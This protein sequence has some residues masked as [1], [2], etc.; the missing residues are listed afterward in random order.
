MCSFCCS[1]GP[2]DHR[3]LL[4]ASARCAV[5]MP[6]WSDL[7]NGSWSPSGSGRCC[8]FQSVPRCSAD[9]ATPP[10]PHAHL[11]L[12]E[13]HSG[14]LSTPSCSAKRPRRGCMTDSDP[15]SEAQRLDTH[16]HNVPTSPFTTTTSTTS[17]NRCNDD[18]NDC[19]PNYTRVLGGNAPIH[20]SSHLF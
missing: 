11:P 4:R 16:T 14:H 10:N 13:H 19:Q 20:V 9:S 8:T 12:G 15:T 17:T 6:L 7:H 18:T 3:R 2:A 1:D 5:R